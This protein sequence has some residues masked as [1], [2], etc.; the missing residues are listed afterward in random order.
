M[1]EFDDEGA[2][3]PEPDAFDPDDADVPGALERRA[4]FAEVLAQNGFPDTL[5]LARDRAA[6]VF[7]DR[8]LEILDHLAEND[9]ES[10]RALAAA[11]DLDKGVV[12]RD[13]QAL[14]RLDVVEFEEAGRA[15]APRLKHAHVAVEPVV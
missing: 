1:P 12:S 3:V 9:P 10:V 7:H 8:R 6:T 5:V 11:L 2:D 13:L 15:K 14:D 4:A